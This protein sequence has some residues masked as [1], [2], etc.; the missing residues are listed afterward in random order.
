[1]KK[2]IVMLLACTMVMGTVPV[3][4]SEVE[5]VTE[6]TAEVTTQTPEVKYEEVETY[7]KL[8]D[9]VV[10]S[11]Q[12]SYTSQTFSIPSTEKPAIMDYYYNNKSNYTAHVELQ[13]YNGSTWSTVSD[14]DIAPGTHPTTHFY[15]PIAGANYRIRISGLSG[16][17]VDGD[18]SVAWY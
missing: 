2:K 9:D 15:F 18:I 8:L 4:A 5:E 17:S 13:M 7:F 11:A 12:G 1:M 6:V 10:Y 14:V 16:G 3:M